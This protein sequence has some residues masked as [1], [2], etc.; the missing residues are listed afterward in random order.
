MT[1]CKKI[2]DFVKGLF[3]KKI[4]PTHL[5]IP[6]FN[7]SDW[8]LPELQLLDEVNLHRSECGL[9][10]LKPEKFIRE[11]AYTRTKFYVSLG[12]ATHFN[13]GIIDRAIKSAGFK[14]VYENSA[15]GYTT[16]GSLFKAFK[17]SK[18]HN[19]NMLREDAQYIG[20]SIRF[21]DKKIYCCLLIVK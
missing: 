8:S 16:V 20:I 17:R 1:F 2:I 3:V 7:R 13:I 6:T 21:E 14:Y 4:T 19:E 12:K 5:H 11:Q 18:L 15:F 10:E 9:V